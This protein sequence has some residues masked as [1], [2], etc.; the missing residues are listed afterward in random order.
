M[1]LAAA[2]HGAAPPTARERTRALTLTDALSLALKN[3][4]R[5]PANR[6]EREMLLRQL[7]R[8]VEVAYWE[9]SG[10]RAVLH[11][12]ERGLHESLWLAN[13]AK[14]KND[15]MQARAQVARFRAQRRQAAKLVQEP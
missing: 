9:L 8:D 10:A 12:R 6:L 11:S 13:A 5:R 7:V 14:A 4:A 15:R 1:L 2:A 3:D